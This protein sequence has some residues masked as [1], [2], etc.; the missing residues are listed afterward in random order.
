M[1]NALLVLVI[2][3]LAGCNNLPTKADNGVLCYDARVDM[4]WNA[5]GTARG[6]TL[7]ADVDV[8]TVTTEEWIMLYEAFCRGD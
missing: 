4:P 2:V 8:T 7:D 6:V 1:K 5:S 3:L